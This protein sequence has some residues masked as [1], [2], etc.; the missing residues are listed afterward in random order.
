MTADPLFDDQVPPTAP[1]IAGNPIV[2]ASVGEGLD[3][4]D[5]ELTNTGVLGV[6]GDEVDVTDPQNP[7]V[8][9]TDA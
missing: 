6:T 7:V 4:T 8:N 9:D 1:A 5:G 3:L 2:I